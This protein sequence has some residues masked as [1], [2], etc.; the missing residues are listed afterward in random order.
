[1]VLIQNRIISWQNLI[2]LSDEEVPLLSEEFRRAVMAGS[3]FGNKFSKD[4][5]KH[6]YKNKNKQRPKEEKQ[7]YRKQTTLC[8]YSIPLWI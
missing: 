5:T 8:D 1:M 4:E 2:S 3:K 7:K 6:K